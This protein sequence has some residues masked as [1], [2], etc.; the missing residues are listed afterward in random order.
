MLQCQEFTSFTNHGVQAVTRAV[1]G[2]VSNS[3][4]QIFNRHGKHQS[5][6]YFTAHFNRH[7]GSNIFVSTVLGNPSNFATMGGDATQSF[8]HRDMFIV[9]EHIFQFLSAFQTF[10]SV[11][12]AV[13]NFCIFANPVNGNRQL[14][15]HNLVNSPTFKHSKMLFDRIFHGQEQAEQQIVGQIS[16]IKAKERN[17]VTD[18]AIY[19]NRRTACIAA[20]LVFNPHFGAKHQE[21][22]I[23]FASNADTGSTYIFFQNTHTLDIFDNALKER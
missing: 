16:L 20:V 4:F 11:I 1:T 14:F 9:Q 15:H 19:A 18:F 3:G 17:D 6:F 8:F 7:N 13:F 5:T 12:V 2:S 21:R 23:V 10:T 22:N